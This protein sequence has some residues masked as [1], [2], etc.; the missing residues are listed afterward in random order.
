MLSKSNIA[1]LVSVL[2][3]KNGLSSTQVNGDFQLGVNDANLFLE[4]N[5]TAEGPMTCISTLNV[6]GNTTLQGATTVLSTLNVSGIT[7]INNTLRAQEVHQQYTAGSFALLVPTGTINAYGGSSSPN[8]WLLCDGSAVSR[9]TYAAL[10]AVLSTTYGVGDGSTTFNLPNLKGRVP[11][12]RDAAQTEFDSLGETG[13]A[14]THTL[15][16]AEIPA[17]THTY[18]GV[19][20]QGSA[21]LGD[22]CADEANRPTETSGSTGGGG[23]HNNLQPYLVINYIIKY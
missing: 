5:I 19:S 23:A 4:D 12:G 17:H 20:G 21:N 13:G 11:V 18:L 9:T 3:Y 22:T 6:S 1:A 15:T 10:F 8:G 2:E 7:T 16:I 14:K